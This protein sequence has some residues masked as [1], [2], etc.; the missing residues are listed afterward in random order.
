MYEEK[1]HLCSGSNCI[2]CRIFTSPQLLE[3]GGQS[4]IAQQSLSK[5]QALPQADL[6]TS[7]SGERTDRLAVMEKLAFFDQLT[8][9]YNAHAFM[10]ELQEEV[11]RAHR[12]K[13]PLSL[14]M[15]SLDQFDEI[16]NRY[17]PLGSEIVLKHVAAL[18]KESLREVDTAAHYQAEQFAIILPET[19]NAGALVVAERLSKRV[20]NRPVKINYQ[21]INVTVSVGVASFLKDGQ[22]RDEMIQSSTGCYVQDSQ[23]DYFRPSTIA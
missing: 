23:L 15:I 14:C 20:S 2:F 22:N 3:T 10:R 7:Q 19:N 18:L 21:T 17:G 12:Y 13:R 4:L 9:I 8:G 5:V 16:K 11:A 1:D 6:L